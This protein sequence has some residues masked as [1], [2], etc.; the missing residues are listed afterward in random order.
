MLVASRSVGRHDGEGSCRCD[1]R[2]SIHTAMS[3]DA[4]HVAALRTIAAEISEAFE[5]KGFKVDLAMEADE[6]FTS[7][8]AR[9]MLQRDI[10]IEAA[11][12]AA[13]RLG[14]IDYRPVNGSGREL[15]AMVGATD[16]HYRIKR[17]TLIEDEWKIRANSDS[18]LAAP[19]DPED[20][21]LFGSPEQWVLGWGMTDDAR[22]E[23]VFIARVTGVTDGQP[24]WLTLGPQIELLSG[25]GSA[26]GGRFHPSDDGG[27]PGFD[28]GAEPGET[29][30]SS[31]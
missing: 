15:R 28:T 6:C 27:L 31:P 10:V 11:Q 24:Q 1:I 3:H 12:I 30:T 7:G 16:R 19:S 13:S 23:T 8:Q 2:T 5:E 26:P 4:A 14:V 22:I 21:L 29:G 9:A 18:A 25:P 17:A 20:A